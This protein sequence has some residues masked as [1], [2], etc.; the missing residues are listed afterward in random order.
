M[1]RWRSFLPLLT[2]A[3]L[4][5]ALKNF[6][7]PAGNPVLDDLWEKS[8]LA[9]SLFGLAVRVYTVG[10]VPEGTSARGTK[11]QR[12]DVLNTTGMYSVVRHPLYLGNFLI[13]LGIS[14][15]AHSLFVALTLIL[16]FFLYYE[17]IIFAE[18]DFLRGNFGDAFTEWAGKTPMIIPRFK[19]WRRPSLPFSLKIVLKREYT[20]FFIVAAS[21]TLLE[22]IG[23]LF[24]R[25]KWEFEW[26]WVL[27]FSFASLTYIVLRTLKKNKKLDVEGR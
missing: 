1:F 26:T 17:R 14:L 23:D 27:M 13:W 2:V 8:C 5:V 18:E 4:L 25:G 3:L 11:K 15:F 6:T 10:Y 7:Y 12:A 20:T 24:Y 19:N 21:F 9:V 22:I 16:I